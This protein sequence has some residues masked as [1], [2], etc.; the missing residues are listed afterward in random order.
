MMLND[1]QIKTFEEELFTEI[2]TASKDPANLDSELPSWSFVDADAYMAMHRKYPDLE[3]LSELYY[4][5]FDTL[6]DRVIAIS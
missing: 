3:N 5:F 1:M 2:L 6:V 4:S